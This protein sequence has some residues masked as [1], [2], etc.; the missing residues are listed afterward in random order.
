MRSTQSPIAPIAPAQISIARQRGLTKV[1]LLVALAV[2][3]VIAVVAAPRLLSVVN[4]VHNPEIISA[5]QN[6]N[7]IE[8]ALQTYRQDNGRYP[9]NEQ[10]LLALIIKPSR[11]PVPKGWK[12]GGYID[13]LPRDP[14]G[15]PYQY[16]LSEDGA[17]F[18]VFSFGAKGP[19]EGDDSDTVIRAK[20]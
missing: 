3:A 9:S 12:T 4:H 6:L 7:D 2:I 20:H 5:E 15:H 13:R 17:Q 11:A 1:Q 19:D 10:G 8:Q 14:W 18:D 16:R